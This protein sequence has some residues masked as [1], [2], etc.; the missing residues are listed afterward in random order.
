MFLEHTPAKAVYGKDG[1]LVHA[2]QGITE[3][4]GRP[5]RIFFPDCSH[6]PLQGFIIRPTSLQGVQ[7]LTNAQTYPAAQFFR[8]RR[9]EGNNQYPVNAEFPFKQEPD[10]EQGKGIGFAGTGAGFDENSTAKRQGKGIKR[11][12]L[13]FP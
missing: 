12:H 4:D 1:R 13:S 6:Q 11:L 3:Q 9:G 7:G 10:K 5:G 2:G 8:G